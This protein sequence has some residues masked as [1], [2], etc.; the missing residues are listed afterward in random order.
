MSGLGAFVIGIA[1]CIFALVVMINGANCSSVGRVSDSE[2]QVEMCLLACSS[3]CSTD[4]IGVFAL[5]G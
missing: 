1:R 2:P 5:A 3:I 4:M